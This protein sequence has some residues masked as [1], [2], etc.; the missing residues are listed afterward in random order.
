M[1]VGTPYKID[2]VIL[3]SSVEFNSITS[4]SWRFG[5]ENLVE[6]PAG[7][8]HPMFSGV[9]GVKPAVEFTTTDIG[10]LLAAVGVGG[11]SAGSS[12]TWLKA[13]AVTGSVARATTS[14]QKVTIASSLV[15]WTQIRLPHQGAGTATV[16]IDA[17][18]DGTNDPFVYAGSQALSG[19]LAAGT[20]FGCGP[21][22]INGT[23][24]GGVQEITI[25]SGLRPIRAGGENEEFDTFIGV[26]MTA[27]VVTIKWFNSISFPT[28]GI[29]GLAL[30]GSNGLVFY[31]R[32]FKNSSAGSFSSGT[33]V[34]NATAE[35]VKFVGLVGMATP[36]DVTGNGSSLVTDT[37]RFVLASGSDS[38]APLT[39]TVNS[40]IT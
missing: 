34:A 27:P 12:T 30:D 21:V 33:R 19:N 28:A 25:D 35:H 11:A 2:K 39:G 10:V 24:Y 9:Q 8:P 18:Y 7:H 29:R 3:P 4:H 16:M 1:A 37:L 17:V 31:A 5:I 26:E 15:Y 20:F 23:S 38:V 6:R 22:A 13:A 40:A 32:K 14:H 36:A